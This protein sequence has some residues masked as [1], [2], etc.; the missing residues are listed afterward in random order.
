MRKCGSF[1]V[2]NINVIIACMVGETGFDVD[3]DPWAIDF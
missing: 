1:C 2:I 3:F